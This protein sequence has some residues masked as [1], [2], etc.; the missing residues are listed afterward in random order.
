MRKII[1]VLLCLLLVSPSVFSVSAGDIVRFSNHRGQYIE[2]L[3]VVEAYL[4]GDACFTG[5][6][7]YAYGDLSGCVNNDLAVK[8]EVSPFYTEITDNYEQDGWDILSS[9]RETNCLNSGYSVSCVYPYNYYLWTAS[10]DIFNFNEL[11]RYTIYDWGYSATLKYSGGSWD[12]DTYPYPTIALYEGVVGSV[13]SVNDL[14]FIEAVKNGFKRGDFGNIVCSPN[15]K[16]ALADKNKYYANPSD[17]TISSSYCLDSN[18]PYSADSLPVYKDA[19]YSTALNYW[20]YPFRINNMYIRTYAGDDVYVNIFYGKAIGNSQVP[21]HRDSY[22]V[23]GYDVFD[24]AFYPIMAGDIYGD[25]TGISNIRAIPLDTSKYDVSDIT[26]VEIQIG[27]VI[28]PNYRHLSPLDKTADF[29]DLFSVGDA[30]DMNKGSQYVDYV[31]TLTEITTTTQG[32]N[33]TNDAYNEINTTINVSVTAGDGDAGGGDASGFDT[34]GS[35]GDD[36]TLETMYGNA[37]KMLVIE[38]EADFFDKMFAV[39]L[40]FFSVFLMVF[41]ILG[42][43]LLFAVINL[44]F[45]S[46]WSGMFKAIDEIFKWW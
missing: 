24:E 12:A 42:A 43:L 45:F 15:V 29:N 39:A 1:I 46:L 8:I 13:G 25:A 41:T 3:L 34:G 28:N 33:D 10:E 23:D 2:D 32:G 7:T 27:F 21:F 36:G 38:Q 22:V 20:S 26:K 40:L 35:V 14:E 30:S 44:L 16:T 19:I 11:D 18:P 9:S 4:I 5:V 37:K 31:I 17:L 6:D